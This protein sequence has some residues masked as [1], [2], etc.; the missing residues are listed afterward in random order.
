MLKLET[1]TDVC[2]PRLLHSEIC[3]ARLCIS[4]EH[5]RHVSSDFIDLVRVVLDVLRVQRIPGACAHGISSKKQSSCVMFGCKNIITM[6]INAIVFILMQLTVYLA[7]IEHSP[8]MRKVI[9]RCL[10]QRRRISR[11]V[12]VN[13]KH[14]LVHFP[15]VRASLVNLSKTDIHRPKYS[16]ESEWLATLKS[17]ESSS[18]SRNTM[19]GEPELGV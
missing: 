18:S 3:S 14:D 2:Q 11:Q 8:A 1:R 4:L 16:S 13:Q 6:F 12:R 17:L 19:P 7:M 9:V 15:H 5:S 10:V